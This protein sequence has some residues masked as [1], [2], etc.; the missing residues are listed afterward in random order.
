M[1]WSIMLDGKEIGKLSS[2]EGDDA[3]DAVLNWADE[4][5]NAELKKDA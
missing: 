4:S 2:D 3:K 5:L 1:Y